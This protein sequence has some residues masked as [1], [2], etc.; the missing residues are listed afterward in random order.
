MGAGGQYA[1]GTVAPGRRKLKAIEEISPQLKA[2]LVGLFYLLIFITAPSSATSATV[3]KMTITLVCDTA[4][5]LFL[6]N[7]LKPVSR[8]ASLL[9]ALFRIIFVAVMAVTS[10]NYFGYFALLQEPHSAGAFLTGYLVAL[11]FFGF[12]CLLIGYLILHSTFLPRLLGALIAL[13]GLGWLINS[14]LHFLF[15]LLAHYLWPG[16]IAAAILGEGSLTVWLIVMGVN[17]RR[18]KQQA[19]SEAIHA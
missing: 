3:P 16:I 7:L 4:V 14:F 17:A 11:V 15:P 12:H 5:A 19:A 18:W 1:E 10:L 8:S 9:A 6:Y 2:R 13:A